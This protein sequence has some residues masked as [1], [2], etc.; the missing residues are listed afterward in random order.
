MEPIGGAGSH[1]AGRTGNH[2]AT[3]DSSQAATPD[4][5][6]TVIQIG[7]QHDPGELRDL[8]SRVQESIRFLGNTAYLR[9]LEDLLIRENEY[10]ALRGLNRYGRAMNPWRVRKGRSD[11]HGRNY[12][13]Y[14]NSTVLVPFGA[15]SRRINAFVVEIQRR[16]ALGVGF[17]KVTV[18][19]GFSPRAGLV[20]SYWRRRDATRDVLGMPPRTRRA[21]QLLS[22]RH[23]SFAHQKLKRGGAA[24]RRAAA[25]L[26]T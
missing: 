26:F 25:S 9:D 6:P 3:A 5:G 18:N 17:G 23:A 14:R 7:V 21:V 22:S 20:P 4:G 2:T 8:Q 15:Q 13:D 1:T 24:V 10:H 11:Y 19:A 12:R 16:S